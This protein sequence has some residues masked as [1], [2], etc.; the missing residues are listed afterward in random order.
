MKFCP[1]NGVCTV[2]PT[3]NEASCRCP[4]KCNSI[5]SPV[6]G[7]DGVT[8]NSECHLRV[9]S[10]TQQK[11]IL[12]RQRGTCGKTANTNKKRDYDRHNSV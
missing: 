2:N 3:T 7:S 1:Y 11:R 5:F 10:C 9:S 12:V 8:Y 6:C 4:D